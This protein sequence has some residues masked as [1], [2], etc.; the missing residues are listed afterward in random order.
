MTKS[1]VSGDANAQPGGSSA[2]K[3][4]SLPPKLTPL[5]N[6]IVWSEEGLYVV[7][8]ALEVPA[9]FSVFVD[10][11]F[12]SGWRFVDLD[13]ACLQKLL[14][15]VDRTVIGQLVHDLQKNGGRPTLR[16]AAGL[17]EFPP[18]RQ[19]YYRDVKII[20][21]GAGAEY[22]FEPLLS[23]C[24][25]A[26]PMQAEPGVSD[27][28]LEGSPSQDLAGRVIL[29][30]DEF[31]AAMW[32]RQV[33]FGIDVAQVKEAFSAARSENVVIAH[34]Q[35]P[36]PGLDASLEELVKSLHRDNT[37]KLLPDG[38]VDL[39][40]F[41][42]RFPQ[43]E[44]NTLILKKIPMEPGKPGRDMA[45]HELAPEPPSDL[46]LNALAGSGIR[47]ERNA[48]G[49]FLAAAMTGFLNI[50]PATQALSISEKIINHDGVSLRTTGN[51]ILSGDEYEEHGEVEEHTQVEGKHMTFMANVFGNIT[52][53]AGQVIFKKN[54]ATGTVKNPGGSIRVEA[55]ASRAS[56]EAIGGE[57][58]VHHAEGCVIIGRKVTIGHAVSCDI[59]AE[60][61]AIEIA[62]GCSLAGQRME[63]GSTAAWREIET[64]I[65]IPVPDLSAFAEQLDRYSQEQEE[66]EHK[67]AIKT[68]EIGALM[69]QQDVRNYSVLNT[70][71]RAKQI[72]MTLEQDANWQKLQ[73]RVAPILRQV[74]AL[75]AEL[76]DARFA[77]HEVATKIQAITQKREEMFVDIV[78]KVNAV[79]G[80]T[81]IRSLKIPPDAPVLQSLPARELRARLRES[82]PD[83]TS[84][85]Q[86]SEGTFEW[87]F[88][89]DA[90][91]TAQ[92]SE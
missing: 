64:A 26:Q 35:P 16:L 91:G 42:N 45:G 61:L 23:E 52:S 11:V 80:E 79:T 6:F 86:G 90:S 66:W 44:E 56:L 81:N 84:L 57:V 36:L 2:P 73:D 71:V 4:A 62:E 67:I 14:Y 24:A 12:A 18:E 19:Q 60:E 40:Q 28:G 50:D 37:P 9:H 68:Q 5:P 25:P 8:P 41:E 1:P 31:I 48:E 43:V 58:T 30:L 59:V 49:E 55:S 77:S 65:S 33:R 72:N 78:C 29:D 85:F 3:A 54:L 17:T 46:D 74:R 70:K 32:C 89:H 20:D 88:D 10:R 63:I 13:Y 53:H 87:R 69:T 76:Q 47:V 39:F 27:A 21:E 22:L 38:R 34:M 7:L 82:G 75:N 51:L 15:E 92:S 83:S